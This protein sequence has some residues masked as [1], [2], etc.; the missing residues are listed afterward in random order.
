M[1]NAIAVVDG[2][3]PQEKGHMALKELAVRWLWKTYNVKAVCES[4]FVGLHPDVLSDDCRFVIECGTTDP[5]CVQI[6]LN[7]PRVVW[8]ENIPYPFSDD[9]CLTL[10][11]FGRGPNYEAWQQE[12]VNDMRNAFQKYHRK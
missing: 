2:L 11:I 6:F 8:T 3:G 9:A 7:D 12:K 5:S 1:H 4:Y 10:H